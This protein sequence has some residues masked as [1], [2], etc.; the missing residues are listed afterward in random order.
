MLAEK[1]PRRRLVL[2]MPAVVVWLLEALLVAYGRLERF[3]AVLRSLLDAWNGAS[4]ADGRSLI[5]GFSK[6][7]QRWGEVC[8]A[9]WADRKVPVNS[10]DLGEGFWMLRLD[11]GG[12]VRELAAGWFFW[13]EMG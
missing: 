8:V 2:Q 11:T 6:N 12:L 13:Q 9:P 7:G 3:R 5:F 1:S 10:W 4:K